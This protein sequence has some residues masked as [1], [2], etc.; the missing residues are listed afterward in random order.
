MA[1]FVSKY[2]GAEH[3]E[4]VRLTGVL[5]GQV[6]TLTE[7]MADL[8]ESMA[9][10]TVTEWEDV[11]TVKDGYFLN[12]D[13]TNELGYREKE[14]ASYA[15]A[16]AKVNAGHK[17]R[18]TCS[19]V[20]SGIA[21]FFRDE[22]GMT[23]GTV[24]IPSDGWENDG[25]FTLCR[26]L[27]IEPPN[28]AYDVAVNSYVNAGSKY[29]H[30]MP[31]IE[32]GTEK[33]ALVNTSVSYEEQV[34]TKEQQ[35]QARKNIGAVSYPLNGK[36]IVNFGDSIF[37]L[38]RPPMDI[39]TKLS[40]LTG[41]TVHNCGFA[42]A[43]M[44]SHW[45]E[46]WTRF[47]MFSLADAI[48]ANDYSSQEEALIGDD[49]PEKP[50]HFSETLALLKS[51]DFNEVDIV[52]IAYG[53]N[54]YTGNNQIDNAD[55][56]HDT[57]AFAGALRYSIETLLT[58]YPHLKIVV[59]SQTWRFW[60]DASGVFTEDSD[61]RTNENGVK[62][63]EFVEKTESVAKEY[64][65]PY[66]DNYYATGFNKFNR[67]VYFSETDGTHPLTVGLHVIAANMAKELY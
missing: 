16:V 4:A 10:G 50:S 66:I 15:Y 61:T 5:N 62:L 52:T 23:V 32:E 34:L 13:S 31:V 56:S 55:N 43:R 19:Y 20:A 6:A 11:S 47:S 48:A 17:Y 38:V 29:L 39:S 8:K 33:E 49:M 63:T 26:G 64:H 53:T 44:A 30:T 42:G 12:Q 1:N 46:Y 67:S 59:C 21:A 9:M 54:D 25:T 58:A 24:M 40:E 27:E 7:E 36:V 3:D 65:L 22:N 14:N 51:I 28:S 35:V 57:S 2:T 37:G 60:M 45:N 41:A 18:I